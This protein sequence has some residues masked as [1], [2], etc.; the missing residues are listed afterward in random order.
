MQH[1]S[2]MARQEL[3]IISLVSIMAVSPSASHP[4]AGA[5]SC[6]DSV[7]DTAA[8]SIQLF[9][10]STE[11]PVQHAHAPLKCGNRPVQMLPC[12]PFAA[13]FAGRLLSHSDCCSCDVPAGLGAE[14]APPSVFMFAAAGKATEGVEVTAAAAVNQ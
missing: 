8:H 7:S 5:L 10:A 11:E 1:V 3:H 4:P 9:L 14:G 13:A 12:V 2:A 6:C